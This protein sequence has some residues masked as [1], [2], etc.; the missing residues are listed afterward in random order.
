MTVSLSSSISRLWT[1]QH[2]LKVRIFRKYFNYTPMNVTIVRLFMYLQVVEEGFS[3]HRLGLR[4]AGRLID[5]P[6]S[7]ATRKTIGRTRKNK[8]EKKL[9]V[10]VG[11]L[12]NWRDNFDKPVFRFTGVQCH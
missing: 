12:I 11:K 3:S 7:A 8:A 5:F 4:D 2:T 6:P 10:Q 1:R 9:E